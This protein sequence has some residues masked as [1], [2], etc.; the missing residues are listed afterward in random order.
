MILLG[1]A[2]T[3]MGRKTHTTATQNRFGWTPGTTRGLR[4]NSKKF[5]ILGDNYLYKVRF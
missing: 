4:R 5:D 3:D 2:A 1:Y